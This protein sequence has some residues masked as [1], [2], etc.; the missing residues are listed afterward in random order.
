VRGGRGNT[1][2][3]TGPA[4]RATDASSDLF[5]LLEAYER[6]VILAALG[7]VGGRQRS[8][9]ALLRILPSTLS[10]KMKRL[11]IGRH[12]IHRSTVP[13]G[14]ELCASLLWT[15]SLPPGGTVELRGLNGPVRVEA[16]D[17]GCVE[18]EAI[19]R[20]SRAILSAIEVKVVEHGRGVTVCAVCHGLP[21]PSPHLDRSLS[22]GLANVRVD[23]LAR[24]PPDARVVASTV[25]DDVEVIGV[26]NVE[27][28]TANGRVRFQA[29]PTPPAEMAAS[30]APGPVAERP[31][32]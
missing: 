17:A 5:R 29:L 22:F 26:A 20:G 7:A 23:I 14:D 32:A 16:G 12:R 13:A 10:Q 27:A 28:G 21:E 9:A 15:G 30:S 18:V 25:N 19:R 31:V 1:N 4:A 6:S 3:V 11:G 8:A 24:V 2:V